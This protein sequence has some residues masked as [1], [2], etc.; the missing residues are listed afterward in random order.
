LRTK[1][2]ICFLGVL[3]IIGFSIPLNEESDWQIANLNGYVAIYDPSGSLYELTNISILSLPKKE[4][5]D[6]CAG[7]KVNNL[8]EL[9]QILEGL[10]Q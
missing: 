7:V 6:L 9:E 2:L 5:Q 1:I 8:Y 3:L 4:Q 10:S